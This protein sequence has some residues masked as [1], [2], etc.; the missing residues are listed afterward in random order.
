MQRKHY[1]ALATGVAG[2]VAG[3]AP[4]TAS[5]LNVAVCGQA[6]AP[7]QASSTV[8]IKNVQIQD[9]VKAFNIKPQAFN[10]PQPYQ[11]ETIG[12][13]S[14]NGGGGGGGGVSADRGAKQSSQ[15]NPTATNGDIKAVNK[16]T[17]VAVGG[18]VV[19][20][21]PSRRHRR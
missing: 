7:C 12:A 21:Q 17:S 9:E 10:A 16:V 14:Y 6:D 11:R 20:I 19:V 5:A 8:E 13:A 2:A 3:V 4:G 15:M 18:P 1:F